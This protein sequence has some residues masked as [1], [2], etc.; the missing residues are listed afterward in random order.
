MPSITFKSDSYLDTL[1]FCDAPIDKD[2]M[3][4][5]E[6]KWN[7]ID[8]DKL[9]E[10]VGLV[11]RRAIDDNPQEIRDYDKK[12]MVKIDQELEDYKSSTLPTKMTYEKLLSN[13]EKNIWTF[14]KN[15]NE[16]VTAVA[17]KILELSKGQEAKEKQMN[18]FE[19]FFH[20][21]GQWFRF[22]DFQTESAYGKQL[23]KVM[24]TFPYLQFKAE[25]KDLVFHPIHLKMG[26]NPPLQTL[27]ALKDKYN[28]LPPDQ[29]KDLIND[30][31]LKVKKGH[32]LDMMMTGGKAAFFQNLATENKKIFM[33]ELLSK[34]DWF[35]QV[36]DIVKKGFEP[37]FNRDPNLF[38]ELL[39]RELIEK[40]K[41]NSFQILKDY[42]KTKEEDR[43]KAVD[44][45]VNSLFNSCPFFQL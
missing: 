33:K 27:A 11:G 38:K 14:K 39:T 6:L 45:F 37:S 41:T 12:L 25:I 34:E 26:E 30:V 21:L 15:D 16:V 9:H 3:H 13:V 1:I 24:Q 18:D 10:E 8:L 4:F 35:A 2:A 40:F 5:L 7:K 22:R 19:L 20:K 43:N 31:I 36:E 23:A 29:L 28:A 32:S 17:N 42:Y 44:E